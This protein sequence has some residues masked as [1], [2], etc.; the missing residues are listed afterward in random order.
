MGRLA[1]AC[2]MF[3]ESGGKVAGDSR[4]NDARGLTQRKLAHDLG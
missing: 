3:C 2:R 1:P 4:R